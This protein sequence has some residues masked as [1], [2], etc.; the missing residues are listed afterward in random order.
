MPFADDRPHT[1]PGSAVQFTW[2]QLYNIMSAADWFPDSHPPMPAGVAR[3]TPPNVAACGM[4]HQPNG[5]GRPENASLVGLPA[6]Y[7]LQQLADMKSGTRR[8]SEPGSRPQMLMVSAATHVSEADA[9]AAAAYFAALSYSPT[10]RVVETDRVVPT[11]LIFGSVRVPVTGGGSESI[12]RRIIEIPEDVERVKLHDPHA[13]FVAYVPT[14]SIANGEALVTT[15]GG[16][17]VACAICYGVA[18][19]GQRVGDATVPPIAGRSTM[20]IVRQLYDF[21]HGARAGRWSALIQP[22]VAQLDLDDMIAT[23]A[24]VASRP[25]VPAPTAP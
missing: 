7:I 6:A 14:G 15:G 21:Q 1:L 19:Q 10:V 13:T 25:V 18:L 11:E 20:N 9:E 24:Y 2:P 4:C 16:K 17:T 23:A 12:G 22:T 3:G 5:A 8:S